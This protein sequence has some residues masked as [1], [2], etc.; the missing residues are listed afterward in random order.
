MAI[1]KA[2]AKLRKEKRHDGDKIS[3]VEARN[4]VL[5]NLDQAR[6]GD[7]ETNASKIDSLEPAPEGFDDSEDFGEETD[8]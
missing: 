3:E 4:M 5:A 6:I 8:V 7:L 1:T 2:V